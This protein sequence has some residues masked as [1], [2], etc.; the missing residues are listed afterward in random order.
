M[1]RMLAL[2]ALAAGFVV[3]TTAHAA[4]SSVLGVPCTVQANGQRFCSGLATSWDGIPIDVN[5]GL[6]PEPDAKYPVIGMYHGWGGTK[7]SLSGGDAQRA[8]SRGYAVF[9]ITDRGWGRS[10]ANPRP[11]ECTDNPGYIHLMHDAYEVRDA[12]YL[13]GRLADDGVIDP[14]RI[15]ATGGSYGGGMAIALGALRNRI[16]LPDGGLAPW[17]SPN[18]TPLQIA[19]TVPQ[20]TWSDLDTALM[21]NGSSLDYVTNA[22]YRGPLGD[23][24]IGVQKQSWNQSLFLAGQ[25]LGYYKPATVLDPSADIAGWKATTDSGGP[26]DG[27]AAAQA[28]TDELAANHSALYIDDSVPPAPALL[29]NG[30]NDDLFPVDESVR[31]YNKVRARWP[32][33]PIAMFHLDFGHNPRAGSVSAADG[34]ALA[35]AADA[36]FDHYLKGVGPEPADARG[37]VDILTSKCPASGAGTRYHAASWAQLAPG[38]IRLDGAAAQ[39]I[40]APGTAP[41]NPFTSGDVCTTTSSAANASAATYTVPAAARAYT[42][43]GSPTIVATF[44]TAGANDF[45]AARLYDVDGAAQRLIARGVLRPLGPGAGPTRQVFQLHPQA[46]A[47]EPGHALKLEL[48]SQDAPYLRTSS[49]AAPQQSVQVS[50]LQLRLPV[51]AA[52]G[53]DLG[54]G[55]AVAAPAAKVVPRGYKLAAGW[56][57]SASGTASGTVAATLS[58]TLGPAASFG[59]FQPGVEHV[60]EASTTATVTSTAGDATLSAAGPVHLRNGAFALAQPLAVDID[61]ATWTGPV[62]NGPSA[63]TFRQAIASTDALRSGAYSA[64]VTFSLSTTNP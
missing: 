59:V 15:G 46:W 12:Q 27:N 60:Y 22:T 20:F 45:V 56:P 26:Y 41:S 5:V 37:G 11:K 8:L 30:W 3:P 19:A 64:A 57:A 1:R 47:V 52:P 10:C 62:S 53:T 43:A 24:R 40:Q 49:A 33:A 44:T 35:A 48:L 7:L 23:H 18:G 32:N 21:P 38:E 54:N 25:L 50:D 29:A 17:R 13:L 4:V 2:A 36:W 14:Q 42:L 39:T 16:Q 63:I 58:L 51:I 9:T 6:P 34:A 28:M 61:P 31:Y 55:V